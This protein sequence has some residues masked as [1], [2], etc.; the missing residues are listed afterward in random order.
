MKGFQMKRAK[1]LAAL[2]AVSA[3][4]SC[5]ADAAD[6][7]ERRVEIRTDAG[8]F[9]IG[10]SMARAPLTSCAFL[11]A[12]VRGDYDGVE[13]RIREEVVSMSDRGEHLPFR[14]R[15]ERATE[16]GI[17]VSPGMVMLQE[18]FDSR[19]Q[20]VSSLVGVFLTRPRRDGVEENLAGAPF[21]RVV[22]GLGVLQRISTRQDGAEGV[23]V[24]TARLL[25]D[26]PVA[27]LAR[28]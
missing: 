27:C 14:A 3:T 9:V 2:F 25:D 16:T 26:L 15:M 5:A 4:T 6:R 7:S 21:G 24:Q 8:N 12:A 10:A 19:S 1:I 23:N 11:N 13:L 17:R 18:D 20:S 22:R 28:Q